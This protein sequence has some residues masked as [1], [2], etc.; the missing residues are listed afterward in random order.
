MHLFIHGVG[1]RQINRP[2]PIRLPQSDSRLGEAQIRLALPQPRT[3]TPSETPGYRHP[4]AIQ[5]RFETK[6]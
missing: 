2:K 4:A 3:A 5:L 1:N 6:Q